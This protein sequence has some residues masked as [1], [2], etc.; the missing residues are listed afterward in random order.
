MTTNDE[1]RE[2]C[3]NKRH[4]EAAGSGFVCGLVPS[5]RSSQSELCALTRYL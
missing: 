2:K 5:R 4:F 3:K 1:K